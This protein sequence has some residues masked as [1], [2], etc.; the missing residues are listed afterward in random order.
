MPQ[1]EKKAILRLIMSKLRIHSVLDAF[2]RE[3][4]AQI[5]ALCNAA[6]YDADLLRL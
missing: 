5:R 3:D 6:L 4:R 1:F 2:I